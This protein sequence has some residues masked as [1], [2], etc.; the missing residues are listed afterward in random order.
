M[1][2]RDRDSGSY[3]RSR[4]SIGIC[5]SASLPQIF[6]FYYGVL[7]SSRTQGESRDCNEKGKSPLRRTEYVLRT[8]LRTKRLVLTE[9]QAVL[10]SGSYD[11]SRK[12]QGRRVQATELH[13]YVC[14]HPTYIV[15]WFDTT[16][17]S[18]VTERDSETK[19]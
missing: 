2:T 15:V 10:G 17:L 11:T 18:E 8:C 1:W 7:V 4:R 16:S 5:D 19:Q 6:F 9:E 13:Y 14:M 12:D 3:V